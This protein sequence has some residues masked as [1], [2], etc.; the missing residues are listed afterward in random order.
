MSDN[1]IKP[2]PFEVLPPVAVIVAPK[3]SQPQAAELLR[4]INEVR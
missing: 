1:E 2:A 4:V 3:L